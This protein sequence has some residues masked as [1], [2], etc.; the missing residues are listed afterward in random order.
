M[1]RRGGRVAAL[2]ASA[3]IDTMLAAAR[4]NPSRAERAILIAAYDTL[5]A[6]ADALY[7][8]GHLSDVIAG[9]SGFDP[10]SF[11]QNGGRDRRGSVTGPA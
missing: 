8:V 5:R 2:D 11:Y 7:S 1:P 4:L 6:K 3:A 10:A 9:G